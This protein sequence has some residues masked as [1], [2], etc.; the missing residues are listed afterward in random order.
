MGLLGMI[1]NSV[2]LEISFSLDPI[3]KLKSVALKTLPNV[4]VPWRRLDRASGVRSFKVQ[5]KTELQCVCKQAQP[6]C[7]VR[8]VLHFK[9]T[10]NESNCSR[11]LLDKD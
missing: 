2:C 6:P 8:Q 9:R 4:A 5:K 1:K 11:A 3:Y 7:T 10:E